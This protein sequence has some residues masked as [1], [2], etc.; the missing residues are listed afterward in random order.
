MT[1]SWKCS[2]LMGWATVFENA[3]TTFM[4]LLVAEARVARKSMRTSSLLMVALCSLGLFGASGG[5]D[6]AKLH[7]SSSP[8][9]TVGFGGGAAAF[10]AGDDEE[11]IPREA[12]GSTAGGWGAWNAEYCGCGVADWDVA[13]EVKDAKG[14]EA[15][16]P[17]AALLFWVMEERSDGPG[18]SAPR[19][20]T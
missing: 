3:K 5:S 2:S 13:G 10:G 9:D 11:G 15:R 16:V 7:S 6:D 17:L 14:D 8:P 12:K 19:S 18:I 1:A 20:A 4:A